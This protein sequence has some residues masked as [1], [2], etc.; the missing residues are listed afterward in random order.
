MSF[1][2]PR[3]A[4]AGSVASLI[5][6][7]SASDRKKA[8]QPRTACQYPPVGRV[9]G[10]PMPG[11]ARAIGHGAAQKYAFEWLDGPA[12]RFAS[13][14]RLRV[15]GRSR[16]ASS[17]ADPRAPMVGLAGFQASTATSRRQGRGEERRQDKS[18]F[19]RS[20]CSP[21]VAAL[22]LLSFVAQHVFVP[23]PARQYH[24]SGALRAGPCQVSRERSGLARFNNLN[25]N[26][27]VK[28]ASKSAGDWLTLS[29]GAIF[30]DGKTIGEAPASNEVAFHLR[31]LTALV[32][33]ASFARQ[34]RGQRRDYSKLQ[35]FRRSARLGRDTY[36]C[37]TC[38]SIYAQ[39][40]GSQGHRVVL[41]P[42]IFLCRTLKIKVKNAGNRWVVTA[43]DPS[44]PRGDHLS[45]AYNLPVSEVDVR[46]DCIDLLVHRD[47]IHPRDAH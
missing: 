20:P 29:T 11:I 26:V 27:K 31:H 23:L 7:S 4:S 16:R 14:V 43:V 10:R 15:W 40:F 41:L 9:E 21:L 45:H 35:G 13:G 22:S 33:S 36:P 12:M 37:N 6:A 28:S 3:S 46:I 44:L 19:V 2:E 42:S 34:Q 1:F 47:V 24:P 30:G 8:C 17:T 38:S 5:S 25:S 39:S 32:T 18:V